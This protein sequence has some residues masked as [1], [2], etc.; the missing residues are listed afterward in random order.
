MFYQVFVD[1]EQIVL[2]LGICWNYD[3]GSQYTGHTG[4]NETGREKIPAIIPNL[5]GV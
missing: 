1:E 4:H 3:P 5:S 2:R